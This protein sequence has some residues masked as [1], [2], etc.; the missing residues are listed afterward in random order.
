MGQ[1]TIGTLSNE[2]SK[3]EPRQKEFSLFN[4][5]WKK[6]NSDGMNEKV[7]INVCINN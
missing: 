5:E 6:E 1:T 7:W 3:V 4:W 2:T